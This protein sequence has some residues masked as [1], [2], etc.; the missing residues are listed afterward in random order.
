MRLSNKTSVCLKAVLALGH[1]KVV[2]LF[3]FAIDLSF[4]QLL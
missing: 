1:I 2:F 3:D 4:I